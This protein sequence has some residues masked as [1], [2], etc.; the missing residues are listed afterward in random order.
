MNFEDYQV[1]ARKTAI[2]P[3]MGTN[4][5]Y[6]TLGLAGE[7]GEVS[8]KVKKIYRDFDGKVSDEKREEI[9]RE[10]GDV[11]WYIANIGSE[12]HVSL[13][14]IA[15]QNIKKLVDRTMRNQVHGDGDNR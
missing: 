7:S 6:P 4:L 13:E 2:Y 1:A 3:F 8:E 9:V 10:L 15:L 14:Y 11:L 5:W 12:L